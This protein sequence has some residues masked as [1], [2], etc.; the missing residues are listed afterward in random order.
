MVTIRSSNEIILSLIDYYRLV[1]PD[2]DTSVGSVSR[3]IFIEGLA[4]QISLLYDEVSG[5][6][7]QQSMRLVVGSDLDKLAK[8]F[9]IIRKQATPSTG[10]ALLTFSSIN[11]T[12]NINRGDIVT[13]SNGFSFSVAAG[14]SVS[15]AAINFYRSVASKFRDQLDIAGISDQF[16]VEVTVAATSSGAVGNIGKFSLNRTAIAG[17]SNVTNINAFAGGTDQEN[18]TS[19]RNRVLSAFSGSSVGT[20][21]GYLNVALGTT[22]VSDAAVIEPGDPLMTRDGTVVSIAT[23]GARTI[24]SEGSGGKVDVIILGSNLVQNTDSFIYH[25]KSNSNDPTSIK[26]DVVLGQ[27]AADVNKTINR[28]RIDDIKNGQLPIQPVEEILQVTGSIS[29]SNFQ[30]KSVDE[31]GIV[32]GNYELVKD[33]GVFGGSPF[34]FD[35]FHWISNQVSGFN[36]DRIKG[37]YNGQDALTFIDVLEISQ[38]QQNVSITNENSTVTFDRSLI[39]LLHTP[40][41]NVT[42]V[43]N[44][45]TGERYIVV[46]QNF[47]KT[48]TFNTSGRIQI[49]G[50]TLPSPS[51]TLQVDYSWI[52]NYDQYSD[53]D[54]LKHTTNPRA[55]SDSVDWGFSSAVR[56]ERILFSLDANGNFFQ[57]TSLL[58][59]GTI[60]STQKFL[61]VDGVIQRVTSGVFTNRL[62]MVISHLSNTTTTVDSI[63]LKN[64][65]VELFK[66]AQGNGS[67]SS[68]TEVVGIQVLNIT[69]IILPTDTVAVDGDKVTTILNSTDV[70]TSVTTSGSS[71]G[72]QITIPSSLVDTTANS[73]VLRTTYITSITDLASTAI[74]TL[75]MSRTG[76]GFALSDN[77]GFGNFS[78]VNTAHR[79]NQVVQKNLSNQFFVEIGLLVAD[80]SLEATQVVSVIRLSD[81][82]ELWNSDN[83]G[84][85]TTGTSG[86]YQLIFSGVNT[87]ATGDR[88]LVVYYAT[89]I[90]RFQPFSFSNALIKSRTDSLQLDVATGKF[91]L[92][93]NKFTPQASNVHFKV[94]EPNTDTAL[95]TVTDGYLTSSGD[96]TAH[97]T[98]LTVNFSSLADLTHKKIKITNATDPNDSGTYDIVS[99]DLTSNEITITDV[100]DKLTADQVSVIRLLDGQEIWN[101]T[102]VINAGSNKILIAPTPNISLND[103]VYVLFFNFSPLK[104][105]PTRI[106]GSVTDQVSN[107]GIINISGTTLSLAQDVVFTAIN[108]GLKL[109]L[110]EAIRKALGLA[111]TASIP[112]NIKIAKLIK[113]EKVTTV[114]ASN[115]TVLEVLATYDTYNTILQ[116]NL[117]Y[118]GEMLS[119]P[120]L[121]SLEFILPATQNNISDVQV[122]NLPKLGDKLR[123]T[124]YFVMR[125]DQEDLA[126]T[127]NG[128]LYTNKKF[129]LIDK[130]F[131]SS[132]FRSS[133]STKFTATSFTQPNLGARYKVTYDYLAPKQNERIVIQYSFNKLIS[134]TTFNIENSRPINADVL[135]RAAKLLLLDLTIN[136]VIADEFKTSTATVLQNLRDQLNTALTTTSLS[137]IIDAPTLINVAQAV[138]GVSRARI[139]FFNKTGQSGSVQKIQAQADEFFAPNN[140]IINTETR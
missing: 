55:V 91:Y 53:Y 83:P 2:L 132:G 48:G 129:A 19:F 78:P 98:S 113:L 51:D 45:N 37:Q 59:I 87:P 21:L 80:F 123:A 126:Y 30:A 127:R 41:T 77:N 23:D 81:G 82:L 140:I 65:N 27:I 88:A 100:M 14:L 73:I 108:S 131:V 15:P 124:F 6:S 49:S 61:E 133:Q 20:A 97:I 117:L 109:N 70:F 75:P 36:E 99:Y 72:N 115:D 4:S 71:S 103:K 47:D 67:F 63:T 66:T 58:P 64:T 74:T 119:D 128:T 138:Q 102:G 62:S 7:S 9:G 50:S 39:K 107:T 43:F 16:A 69:T 68:A 8:N 25:D 33:T 31:F 17:V 139:L 114:S 26:N 101:Y 57:G 46:D 29:G 44:V 11:S 96:G 137:S 52:V 22:G 110:S 34:G 92:Q 10:V 1:Q 84:T 24:L 94:I 3:D 95:F 111:S 40:A 121:Q 104:K 12:I 38:A 118:V 89:D 125:G 56:N 79:E 90:K 135:V 60:I 13:A 32:S 136:V 5:V 122:H 35:T 106:V 18:D 116:N 28:R 130:V 105:S 85:I 112:S 134:D 93:I 86:N 120:T 76:N 42:R 54:G